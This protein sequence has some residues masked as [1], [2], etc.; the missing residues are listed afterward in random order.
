MIV[1]SAIPLLTPIISKKILTNKKEIQK[2]KEL[3]V[4]FRLTLF[5]SNRAIRFL[6]F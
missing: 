3:I 2:T 6:I 1:L 5:Y 4:I